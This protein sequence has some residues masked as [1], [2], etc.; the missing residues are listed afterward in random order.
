MAKD[1]LKK[2][3]D[4]FKKIGD[5]FKKI[6]KFF[7]FIGDVFKSIF[8]YIICG[9]LMIIKIPQCLK[10]YSLDILGK[11]LYSPFAFSFFIFG[12]TSIEKM[13]WNII[14][15]IDCMCYSMTGFNFVSFPNSVIKECYSCKIY[16]IP[17]F[18]KF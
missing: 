13:L 15:D 10:W 16:P 18:P 7:V 6:G 3:G 12:L 1:P 4:F 8:S 17:K 14:Y 5:F 2:I 9:F 11:T